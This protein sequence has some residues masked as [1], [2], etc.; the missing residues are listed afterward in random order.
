[1][2]GV[3]FIVATAAAIVGGT[4]LLPI[5]ETNY[6]EEVAGRDGQLVSG[7]LLELVLVLSVIGIAVLLFPVLRR[8][9][10]GL[11]LAYVGTRMVEAVLLLIALISALV[12]LALSQDGVLSTSPAAGDVALALRDWTYLLGSMVGLGVSAVILYSLLYR[13]ALVPAWLSLWG[14][15][16]GV[17]ILLR[18]VLEAYGVEFSA[19]V[20][21][22]LA[23]PIAL[24]EMVLAVW[25]IVKGFNPAALGV[26]PEGTQVADQRP[27]TP[28]VLRGQTR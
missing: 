2:V 19:I 25:L 11:A 1:V 9:S 26:E 28:G 13:A 27:A 6:V 15:A 24:N 16:G 17:L 14:L 23:A 20:Q 7:A 4:L 5:S 18:G 10:E 8:A 22:L 12:V 21:G 3:L